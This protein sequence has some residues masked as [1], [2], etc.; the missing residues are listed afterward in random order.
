MVVMV[1]MMRRPPQRAFLK[2]RLREAREDELKPAAR[3][4][5]SMR[6]VAVIA[7]RHTEH[8]DVVERDCERE[9]LPGPTEDR[10]AHDCRDVHA[11]ERSAHDPAIVTLLHALTLRGA[12]SGN[13]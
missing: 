11:E 4:I 2:A 5:R 1:A 13:G 12:S 6:E 10:N 3:P 9:A 7:A 8:A